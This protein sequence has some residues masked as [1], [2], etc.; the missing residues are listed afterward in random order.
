MEG[1]LN[2]SN[3]SFGEQVLFV[4]KLY[5]TP[6]QTLEDAL[7]QVSHVC[8]THGETEV[9]NLLRNFMLWLAGQSF[10]AALRLGWTVDSVLGTYNTFGLGDRVREIQ[11]KIESFAINRKGAARKGNDD[12]VTEA[13]I[14]QKE[15]R[16]KLYND[17]RMF[18]N[19]ITNLGNYLRNFTDK[20]RRQTELKIRLR[21]INELL[22]TQS[23]I[24]P[25]GNSSDPVKWI[26][27][28]AVDDCVVFSSRE[29]APFLLRCEVIL[30]ETATMNDPTSSKLRLPNGKFKI[31]PDSDELLSTSY[32]TENN[33]NQG[34]VNK[35][36][37]IE[38]NGSLETLQCAF[39][40][41]PEDRLAR[42]RKK[43]IFGNHP[44]W[45]IASIIVKAGDDLRQEEFALQLIDMFNRIWKEAGLTC[46]VYPYHA[47]SISVDS[48]IIECIDVA[49]SIDGIK[50]AC[51]VS[52]LAEFFNEAFGAKDSETYLNAQRNF[53]ETMA[54]Y[55][56]VS[57]M[58]QIKDR[59]NGNLMVT[60]E[61]HLVHI[62]FGFMLVTSPGGI[63]FESAPFKLSQDL[64]EVMGGVGSAAFNYFK[65][66]MYQG[67]VAIRDR[68]DEILALVSLMTPYN[69]MPCFGSDPIAAVQQLR[70]RFRFDLETEADFALYV[71]EL[72]MGSVDNWRTRRYDQ[73]QTLQNGIL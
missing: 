48:G 63:N 46:S 39:G 28:I 6:L 68:A 11:D 45:G 55:S 56:I 27:N 26:V 17:E 37:V 25:L 30:D 67:M 50:K 32:S 61:G 58:L 47:L 16:L 4:N 21:E 43:S 44:G 9:Q 57:Y 49:C 69:T 40:E 14:A 41:I 24:F 53:V 34:E 42:I 65:V 64:L 38:G 33:E 54:G 23:L 31:S 18:F 60:S 20:Q 5:D 35:K 72:I 7:L 22:R 13:E 52:Y 3:V 70:S 2:L 10:S 1:L 36:R 73:F 8:I 59:H 51:Q 15:M 62:D 12:E 71:K 66:L 19:V 29:R